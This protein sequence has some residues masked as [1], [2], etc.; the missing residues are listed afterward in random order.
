ME[1]LPRFALQSPLVSPV[2][3]AEQL[4]RVDRGL[5]RQVLPL[6]ASQPE[7]GDKA[8]GAGRLSGSQ[9]PLPTLGDPA[10]SSRPANG[11]SFEVGKST[12]L[13]QAGLGWLIKRSTT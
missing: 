6:A 4:Y 2:A 1:L 13:D 5:S 12:C 11:Y 10:A 7:P 8:S 3:L 9:R